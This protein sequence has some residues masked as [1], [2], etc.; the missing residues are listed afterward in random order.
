MNAFFSSRMLF[1]LSHLSFLLP[2]LHPSLWLISL[3]IPSRMDFSSWAE[4]IGEYVS[5]DES[6]SAILAKSVSTPS[7]SDWTDTS[8]HDGAGSDE[9]DTFKYECKSCGRP[10][11]N[12][13][14]LC[15]HL[16]NSEIHTICPICLMEFAGQGPEDKRLDHIYEVGILASRLIAGA[17]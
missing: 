17:F 8:I 6:L 7:A 16:I 9:G 1:P 13:R 4:D 10:C 5:E 12:V 11:A 3:Y 14:D 15:S 2:G